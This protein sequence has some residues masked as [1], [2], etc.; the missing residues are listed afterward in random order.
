MPDSMSL[1]HAPRRE[2]IVYA[3]VAE[4]RKAKAKMWAEIR[5]RKA[6]AILVRP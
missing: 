5:S 2:R 1:D 3:N 4:Y 6:R